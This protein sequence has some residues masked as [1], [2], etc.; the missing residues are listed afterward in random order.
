MDPGQSSEALASMS[1]D[2]TSLA[3]LEGKIDAHIRLNG[4]GQ[5]VLDKYLEWLHQQVVKDIFEREDSLIYTWIQSLRNRGIEDDIIH[6]SF[7]GWQNTADQED[8]SSRRRYLMAEDEI[9]RIL[10]DNGVPQ[11]DS[12][13][14]SLQSRLIGT[15]SHSKP[16][17][18]ASRSPSPGNWRRVRGYK[19]KRTGANDMPVVNNR[20]ASPS[21]S[22]DCPTNLDPS[23]DTPPAP[24]YRCDF[25]G[26]VGVHLGT[27]CPNNNKKWS[28]NT[29]RKEHA[30]KPLARQFGNRNDRR[31]RSP[32]WPSLP[33]RQHSDNY[34]P[35]GSSRARDE[36]ADS[37]RPRYRERSVSPLSDISSLHCVRG[38]STTPVP[39]TRPS[40]SREPL[41][42]KKTKRSKK[43]GSKTKS[44]KNSTRVTDNYPPNKNN[45]YDYRSRSPEDTE[46]R[47]SYDDEDLFIQNTQ[48]MSFGVDDTYSS[49]MSNS[50]SRGDVPM[51][52]P[53]TPSFD[54]VPNRPAAT[55]AYDFLH[56]LGAQ[57]VKEDNT[58]AVCKSE[59][60]DMLDEVVDAIGSL[61][62]TLTVDQ[63]GNQCRL[64]T[65]PPYSE[66]VI[67]LFPGSTA[68][69]VHAHPRRV[70]ATEMMGCLDGMG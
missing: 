37:Y 22:P 63:D 50:L 62:S 55:E 35:R 24:D 54:Q 68:P 70:T 52:G 30:T 1:I 12:H 53:V 49:N 46:G 17:L 4:H 51:V 57:M 58:E 18:G 41:P 13:I 26:K 21:H 14:D 64:L 65:S 34:R 11:L 40:P 3:Q 67:N 28:L 39:L 66:A 8:P 27:L 32:M 60:D 15:N 5:Q 61:D 25:C 7:K 29:K 20:R 9:C 45:H 48:A 59:I 16:T 43:K 33:I 2:Q 31:E 44:R 38:R 69:I 6:S 19:R 36:I 56:T 23:Y 10:N 42:V 47:L